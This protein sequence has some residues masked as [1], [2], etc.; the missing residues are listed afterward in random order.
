MKKFQRETDVLFATLA[1]N[2]Q[3]LKQLLR[4]LCHKKSELY[5]MCIRSD[6]NITI[7][8]MIREENLPFYNKDGTTMKYLRREDAMKF[9]FE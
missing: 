6:Y 1:T 2:Q 5:F 4:L 3:R 9:D 7:R 8:E